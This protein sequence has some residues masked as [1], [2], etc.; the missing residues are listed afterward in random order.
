[1][2]ARPITALVALGLA[3]LAGCDR[4][5]APTD[6]GTPHNQVALP[7]A[8]AVVT[9]GGRPVTAGDVL[10]IDDA[11]VVLARAPIV[12]GAY[13]FEP[14]PGAGARAVVARLEAPVIGVVRVALVDAAAPAVVVAAAEVITLDVTV[15]PPAGVGFD[16]AMLALTPVTPTVPIS[17]VLWADG[18]GGLRG[19]M[20][21]TRQS[22][23]HF[24]LAVLRGE[25]RVGVGRIV[26]E[27]VK[28][29]STE[30]ALT[31][32]RIDGL[33]ASVPVSSLAGAVVPLTA[34]GAVTL[35]LRPLTA[36][37]R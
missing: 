2:T 17:T 15:A 28:P 36:A 16:W 26:D 35:T 34:S 13:R 4:S 31:L 23:A 1:M 6:N 3:A 30:A 9:V 24:P 14:A 19:S 20:V 21:S 11:G 33:A 32:A 7:A 37:E 5:R 12:D 18:Q 27:P 22:A 29:T 25:Y 10:A 8:G